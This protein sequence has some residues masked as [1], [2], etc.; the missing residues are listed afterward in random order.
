MNLQIFNRINPKPYNYQP[1]LNL[2]IWVWKKRAI[3]GM[4]FPECKGRLGF[5]CRKWQNQQWWLI[6]SFFLVTQVTPN[7]F[8]SYLPMLVYNLPRVLYSKQYTF[9][10]HSAIEFVPRAQPWTLYQ[11]TRSQNLLQRCVPW[12]RKNRKRV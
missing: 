7:S 10:V 2:V 12:C 3:L 5:R 4:L 9:R 11:V 1:S 8:I 6:S